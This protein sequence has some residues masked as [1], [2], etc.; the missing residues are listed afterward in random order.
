[1]KPAVFFDRD[2]VL[3]H[4]IIKEGKP[5]PPASLDELII[6]SN[7]RVALNNLKA[8]GFLIIVVTNQPDVARGQTPQHVVEKINQRLLTELPLDDIR[9][10]YHDDVDNC[11]CRKPKPGLIQQA[12]HDFSIDLTHSY[13]VGDRWKDIAA[14]KAAF[15]RTIWLKNNYA[16]KQPEMMDY[17]A[18]T[19]IDVADWILKQELPKISN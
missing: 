6:N 11:V 8:K 13:M 2:G 12:A 18:D 15:C 7:A 4:A 14:G 17:S 1:M 5:S 19:L 10:C 16:E 3:N 9:V